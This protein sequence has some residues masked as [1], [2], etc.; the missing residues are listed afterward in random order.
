MKLSAS[1]LLTMDSKFS[2]FLDEKYPQQK[3][4]TS[5]VIHKSFGQKI[6]ECLKNPAS[7]DKN[8]RFYVKKGKFQLLDIPSLGIKEPVLV[9]PAPPDQV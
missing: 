5:G 7:A 1:L 8:F 2:A 3:R 6:I 9:V 4:N